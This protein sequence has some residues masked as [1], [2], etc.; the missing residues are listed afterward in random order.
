MKSDRVFAQGRI[1]LSSVIDTIKFMGCSPR[2]FLMGR[3]QCFEDIAPATVMLIGLLFPNQGWKFKFISR[4]NTLGRCTS[5]GQI[6]L[7]R[8]YAMDYIKDEKKVVV[9]TILH[10]LAHALD[11]SISG[12]FH[13]HG[14]AWQKY[15]K[16][17]GIATPKSRKRLD[18]AKCKHFKYKLV[19]RDTGEV[20]GGFF[21]KPRRD[22]SQSWVKGRPETRGMLELVAAG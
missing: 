13:G 15:A 8:W 12:T 1:A 21:K 2:R 22:F 19:V 9:D 16:L 20:V 14:A 6:E 18:P 3:I 11:Y 7:S 5:A 4:H 17:M 10:E